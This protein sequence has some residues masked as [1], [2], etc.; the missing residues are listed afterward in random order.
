MCG[1]Q[2]QLRG[3]AGRG[4]RVLDCC[5]S[6]SG[7]DLESLWADVSHC[8]NCTQA[9]PPTP[10]PV[11]ERQPGGEGLRGRS[12]RRGGGWKNHLPQFISSYCLVI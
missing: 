8:R 7:L 6:L 11:Q 9:V 1:W 4:T 12:N 5:V 3:P 10:A 2:E